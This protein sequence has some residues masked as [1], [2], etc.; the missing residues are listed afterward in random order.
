MRSIY[1][2]G[3]VVAAAILL[4]LSAAVLAQEVNVTWSNP[5]GLTWQP[6]Y[7]R[8]ADAFMEKHPEINV[9]IV[10]TPSSGYRERLYTTMAGGTAPDVFTYYFASEVAERG[11]FEDL[12]PYI[13]RDGLDPETL[14]FPIARERATHEG[15]YYSVPRDTVY[16]TFVY[17]AEVFDRAG[18]ERPTDD[19]TP[20]E[21]VEKLVALTSYEGGEQIYG[22]T[23]VGRGML[24][25]HPFAYTLGANV[26]DET[27]RQVQ[28]YLDS[29]ET[30]EAIQFILDLEEKGLTLPTV[31]VEQLAA[32]QTS[33]FGSGQVALSMMSWNVDPL[34][35]LDFEMQ[36]VSPPLKPG[37]E[38]KAWGDSVQYYM[39]SGSSQKEAAWE[40]LKFLSGPEAGHIVAEMDTW[41]PPNP[42]VWEDLNWDEDPVRG[43]AWQQAQLPSDTPPYLRSEYYS[44]IV[45]PR[46]NNIWTR[47]QELGQ[48]PLEEIVQEEAAA[49]QQELDR[50]YDRG[51]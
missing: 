14:W 42:S 41:T 19:W 48:R 28:G 32:Q 50:A 44:E 17:N 15:R 46:L 11:L 1:K 40:L 31:F 3:R 4:S 45:R 25:S 23:S 22:M 33:I 29:P 49:A 16:L 24:E 13:E 36:Y 9:E 7:Q 26:V 35:E 10:N 27:G 20:E 43:G 39:W 12:T 21:M 34:Y 18:V 47:Y 37:V 51:R 38:R 5:D 2:F 6:T 30:I 8:L